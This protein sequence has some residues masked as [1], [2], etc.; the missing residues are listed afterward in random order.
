MKITILMG[1]PHADGETAAL[2]D[3]FAEGAKKA[4]HEVVRLDVA[5]MT[6]APVTEAF[7]NDLYVKQIPADEIDARDDMKKI[8][9]EVLSSEGLVFASPVYYYGF[10]AQ[11]KTV[12]DRFVSRLNELRAHPMTCAWIADCGAPAPWSF[13]GIE[14]HYRCLMRYHGWADAGHLGVVGTMENSIKNRPDELEAARSL[15][16]RFGEAKP[17][18][19]F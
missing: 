12:I 15:G 19:K 4:G 13:D 7:L 18:A 9:D 5:K 11:L 14:A 1:S 17:T 16:E 8:L 10:S 3:A 6:V 2:A